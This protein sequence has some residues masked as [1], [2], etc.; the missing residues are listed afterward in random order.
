MISKPTSNYLFVIDTDSYAGNFDRELCG[1]LTGDPNNYHSA[2]DYAQ[3]CEEEDTIFSED[4][5]SKM[6][7]CESE[8]GPTTVTII[9]NDKNIYNS[10][11]IL[12]E[13][14]PTKKEIETMKARAEKFVKSVFIEEFCSR[15][16]ILGFRLLK[17]E[18]NY[19]EVQ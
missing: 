14:K 18:I 11:A 6:D 9:K 4:I 15:F 3:M 8:N 17:S 16:N 7:V 10:V 1:Y 19:K 12:F 5:I 2:A 13:K